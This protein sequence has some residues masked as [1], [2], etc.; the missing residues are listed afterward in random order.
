[1]TS[2]VLERRLAMIHRD[3]VPD[4]ECPRE[5]AVLLT[6]R[7]SIFIRQQRTRRG[8]V[9]RGEMRYGTALVTDAIPKTLE[10]Y[11]RT[12]LETLT[13]DSENITVPHE[14]VISLAMR[15]EELRFRVRD[16]IIWLTMRRQ[17]EI[18]QVF[19]FEMSYRP[20]PDERRGLGFTWFPWALISS[21]RGK[22]KA[23]RRSS[24]NTPWMPS[25]CLD[26]PSPPTS[27]L[28]NVP[29][30]DTT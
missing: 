29:D 15:R 25:S 18:F 5:Y 17:G 24:A 6:E 19:D 2:A 23:G 22:P 4:E 12:S 16:F 7:R 10:D 14:D 26:K 8:F 27:F 30:D 9:L 13:A 3:I 1:M 21:I 20:S 11:D 28:R